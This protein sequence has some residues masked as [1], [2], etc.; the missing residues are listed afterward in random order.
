MV[1]NLEEKIVDNVEK[2]NST[3]FLMAFNN[4]DY[5]IKTRYNFN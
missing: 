4:L 1:K 2:C 5:S 3:R